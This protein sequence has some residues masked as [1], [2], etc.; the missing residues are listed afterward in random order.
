MYKLPFKPGDD[1][2]MLDE[3]HNY[4]IRVEKN[5]IAGIAL[6]GDG[7]IKCVHKDGYVF[8]EGEDDIYTSYAAAYMAQQRR[9]GESLPNIGPLYLT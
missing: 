1:L 3:E 7:E 5:G 9:R 2:Y 4:E 8:S 6:M